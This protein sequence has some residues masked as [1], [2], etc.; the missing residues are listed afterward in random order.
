MVMENS[1]HVMFAGDGAEEYADQMD[2]ERV[3]NDYFHTQDRYEAWQRAQERDAMSEEQQSS[4]LESG[5]VDA[6]NSK[7]GTVGCVVLDQDGNL[8]AGT[9]TGGMTNKNTAAWAMCPL[10]VQGHTPATW[11]Q[12]R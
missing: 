10:L 11:W 3:E 2:V 12:Y 9:S 4:L 8:V 6:W 1:E 7:Y 5:N